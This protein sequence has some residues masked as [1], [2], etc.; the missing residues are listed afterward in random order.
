LKTT[1]NGFERA[2]SSATRRLRTANGSL[3]AWYSWDG[4]ER[5]AWPRPGL[6]M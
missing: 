6:R 5:P 3:R 1:D 2:D 4:E